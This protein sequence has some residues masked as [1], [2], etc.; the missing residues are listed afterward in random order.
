M[1][2]PAMD[3]PYAEPPAAPFPKLTVPTLVIWALDDVALPP[4]N[5]DGMEDLVP[6]LSVVKVPGCGHFVPWEDPDAVNAAMDDFL[7]RT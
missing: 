2:V 5:L 6:N 3:E 7:A 1:T 4:C